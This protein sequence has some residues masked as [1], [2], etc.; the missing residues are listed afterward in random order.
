MIFSMKKHSASPKYAHLFALCLGISIVGSAI[1][2]YTQMKRSCGKLQCITLPLLQQSTVAEVYESTDRSYLALYTLPNMKIRTEQRSGISSSD[3]DI[4]TKVTVMRMQGQFETARSP[5]PGMLSDA[6][7]C[8]EKFNV[9]PITTTY[10]NQ[11]VLFFSGYLN[12]RLQ[13]GSCIDSEIQFTGLNAVL[14]CDR[15]H[16]WYRIEILIPGGDKSD[17]QSYTQQLQNITCQ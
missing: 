4:L 6:I 1:F 11:E 17:T 7:T 15:Q 8:D 5:Y 9:K 2:V 10:N 3:A 16:A 14:Y 13:Y 12:N